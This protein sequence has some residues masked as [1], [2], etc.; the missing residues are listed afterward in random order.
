MPFA[1]PDQPAQP[2]PARV[3]L[4]GAEILDARD[5]SLTAYKLDDARLG[6]AL[7]ITTTDRNLLV[8]LDVKVARQLGRTALDASF[9]DGAERQKMMNR[10]TQEDT[11]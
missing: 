5:V 3:D 8:P 1:Q 7:H 9:A 2:D 4:R 11:K 10:L 6:L